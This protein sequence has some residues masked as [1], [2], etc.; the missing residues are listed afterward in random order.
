MLMVF[1]FEFEVEV[2][3][4]FE[5]WDLDFVIVGEI[6]VE[7]CFLIEYGGKIVVDLLLL[8]LLLSVFEYDCLWVELIIDIFDIEVFGVDFIDGLC[9]LFSSLNYVGKQWVYE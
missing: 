6:I 5:K 7:D 1:K 4:V 8:K 3:V 9:V 2:C